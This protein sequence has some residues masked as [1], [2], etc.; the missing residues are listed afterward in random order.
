MALMQNAKVVANFGEA[1]NDAI[2]DGWLGGSFRAQRTEWSQVR[3][4]GCKLVGRE[5]PSLDRSMSN[6]MMD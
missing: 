4:R 3:A 5:T 2:L 1:L 6:L